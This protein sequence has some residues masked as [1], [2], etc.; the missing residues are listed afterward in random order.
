M[1]CIILASVP[2]NG[3]AMNDKLVHDNEGAPHC[4]WASSRDSYLAYHDE[5]GR[6]TADGRW[7][8]G[9][10]CLEARARSPNPRAKHGVSA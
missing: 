3:D 9:K 1:V 4:G 8:F 6:P 5:W 10:L 7:V 2:L